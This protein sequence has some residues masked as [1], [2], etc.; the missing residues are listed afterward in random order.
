MASALKASL[1]PYLDKLYDQFNSFDRI[2]K[3]PLGMLDRGLPAPDFEICS[4][5]VAGLSY[6]RVEQ[7]QKSVLLLWERLTL[8]GLGPRGQGLAAYL[9]QTFC[10]KDLRHALG[11]WSHRLNTVDDLV[12]LFQILNS[13]LRREKSLCRLFQLS[14]H[15]DSEA[16]LVNF[17]HHFQPVIAKARGKA[18]SGT[19]AAWFA[20]SPLS[21]STC[22]RL[23]MWL[24]WMVRRDEVDPGLWQCTGLH[25]PQLPAVTAARLFWPVDTHIFQW[26]R[27]QRI[28]SRKSPN[29]NCV[30]EITQ[31][32]QKI[33]PD[34]PVR[35]DFAICHTGMQD[36][37]SPLKESR[38][39]NAMQVERVRSRTLLKGIV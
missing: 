27:R 26:A 3:D 29:W 28:I 33:R 32:F 11:D 8:F 24:R 36:F 13:L 10:E 4:F 15:P 38:E 9:G 18:W 23:M 7:I 30:K 34:D 25:D 19:G 16:Q 20:S 39:R 37:R 14:Y 22:K 31:A 35:Y 1:G 5:I 12:E 21:G 17:C 6:G 2:G